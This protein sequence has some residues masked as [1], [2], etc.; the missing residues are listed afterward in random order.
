MSLLSL[1]LNSTDWGVGLWELETFG[2]ETFEWPSGVQVSSAVYLRY[3]QVLSSGKDGAKY[4]S[5][6][7]AFELFWRPDINVFVLND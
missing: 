1:L 4:S 7:S 5:S 2:R 3:N 6:L